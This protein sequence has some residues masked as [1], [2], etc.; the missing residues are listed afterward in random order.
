MAPARIDREVDAPAT[1]VCPHRG[2]HT[3]LEEIADHYQTDLPE[4]RPVITSC[5]TPPSP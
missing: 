5:T 1:E 2:G 3:G 4:P